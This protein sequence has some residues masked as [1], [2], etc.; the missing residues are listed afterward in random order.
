MVR[1]LIL[2]K[3]ELQRL[4]TIMIIIRFCFTFKSL[5]LYSNKR[6][7]ECIKTDFTLIDKTIIQKTKLD[8]N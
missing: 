6:F 8:F 2:C 1:I 7:C 3:I 5:M 4:I